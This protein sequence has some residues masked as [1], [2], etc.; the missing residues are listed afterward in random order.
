MDFFNLG[1]VWSFFICLSG[2]CDMFRCLIVDGEE[3]EVWDFI[4]FN[5]CNGIFSYGGVLNFSFVN[6]LVCFY[7]KE[8]NCFCIWNFCVNEFC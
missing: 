7:L 4:K 8:F 6:G 5:C 2:F 1:F 3:E